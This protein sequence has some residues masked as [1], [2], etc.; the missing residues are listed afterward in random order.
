MAYG[1]KYRLQ[2]EPIHKT[3]VGGKKTY[4]D[5]KQIRYA[6]PATDVSGGPDPFVLKYHKS[7]DALTEPIKASE[8]I[9]SLMSTSDFQFSEMFIS[10]TTKDWMVV[11]Y[12]GD[13]DLEIIENRD[14]QGSL[15]T[16]DTTTNFE[17]NKDTAMVSNTSSD[18]T[19][20][21]STSFSGEYA[22]YTII[23]KYADAYPDETFEIFYNSIS[24]G[25]TIV[26]GAAT[27][28]QEGT[29]IETVV[30]NAGNEDQTLKIVKSW[31]GSASTSTARIK[32][33]SFKK[34]GSGDHDYNVYWKGWLQPDIYSEPLTGAPYEI[35]ITATDGLG[36]LR[37]ILFEKS[38]RTLWNAEEGEFIGNMFQYN[39]LQL[40]QDCLDETQVYL[41]LKTSINL[42]EQKLMNDGDDP[43]ANVYINQEQ[44]INFDEEDNDDRQ[45]V[46]SKILKP[47]YARIY[48]ADGYWNIGRIE[49]A[50]RYL[51]YSSY[52]Y[53]WFLNTIT[54]SNTYNP[55]LEL[56]SASA[57]P[58]I[59]FRDQSQY[60]ELERAWK[61][62]RLVQNTGR[63]DSFI[64]GEF[65]EDYW[66]NSTTPKY[67]SK[68]NSVSV[69]RNEDAIK[70]AGSSATHD[71][72]TTPNIRNYQATNPINGVDVYYKY[73][74]LSVSFDYRYYAQNIYSIAR[75]Y[76]Y[77]YYA[78][79]GIITT[80][81]SN[82]TW[83]GPTVFPISINLGA[84][85]RHNNPQWE[86]FTLES[87]AVNNKFLFNVRF[88]QLL[89]G[90]P[91]SNDWLEIKNVRIQP[92][93]DN[94]QDEIISNQTL[95][96]DNFIKPDD[97]EFNFGD[98][99]MD[100]YLSDESIL[101][102]F[103]GALFDSNK[104]VSRKDWS[105]WDNSSNKKDL[106]RGNL[107][108]NL[109][110]QYYINRILMKGSIIGNISMDNMIY[111]STDLNRIFLPIALELNDRHSTVTGEW[112]E[113]H[114]N[115][116]DPEVILYEF[117][118]DDFDNTDY[119]AE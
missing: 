87:E 66:T 101:S 9:F 78:N 11:V 117:D 84:G 83:Y 89:Q 51:N 12:K 59:R 41:P 118:G 111:D 25:K 70:I 92:I 77:V 95:N 116:L 105:E 31:N 2:Y 103:N 24:L 76:F 86:T 56:T 38:T 93:T 14:F 102:Q 100:Q 110:L 44:F 49:Y 62:V 23:V 55:I 8:A 74:K 46:I 40:I 115:G 58:M 61:N 113:L 5:F 53:D 80:L 47:Y 73:H 81:L 97:L 30:I 90:I 13:K 1:T 43:L 106:I 99:E 108:Q 16:W 28:K 50:S 68:V 88:Y 94:L 20:E 39:Q 91:S 19:L 71:Y 22:A 37:N 72:N 82:G 107:N 54:N 79:S 33:V 15:E 27:Q 98:V 65:D 104:Q 69:S 42:W 96:A 29:S 3:K 6:G 75:L 52:I 36:S 45:T 119:L 48:Q 114:I 32:Y 85:S 35:K 21:Q 63:R 7:G 17:W 67:W 26:T 112:L 109:T 57:I 64:W 34:T 60:M 10:N 18:A 4:I